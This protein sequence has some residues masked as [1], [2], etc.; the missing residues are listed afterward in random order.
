MQAIDVVKYGSAGVLVTLFLA[1]FIGFGLG[2][3]FKNKERL[4]NLVYDDSTKSVRGSFINFCFTVM[5]AIL[6]A[7]GAFRQNVSEN[8][9]RMETL[10]IGVFA[11]SFGIYT[12]RQGYQAYLKQKNGGV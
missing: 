6:I 1:F 5:I 2:F 7:I 10:I 11:A 4:R 12:I 8:L 9:M 3:F